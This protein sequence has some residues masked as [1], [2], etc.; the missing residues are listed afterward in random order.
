MRSVHL[1][2]ALLVL[3]FAAAAFWLVQGRP[4]LHWVVSRLKPM[5]PPARFDPAFIRLTP[6]DITQLPVAVRFDY[7]MGSPHGALTYNAQPFRIKMHLGD[8]L[9]GIGG[10]NSDLGDPAYAAGAGRVIFAGK[11]GTGWG[12]MIILAHRVPDMTDPAEEHVVQTVYAHLEDMHVELGQVV[13]RG[14]LIGTVGNASGAYLAHLHFEIRQ[15]PYV[16][17]SVGYATGPLNRL[18]PE[19]FLAQRRGAADNVLNPPPR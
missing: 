1:L 10:Q 3:T 5:P 13:Q 16:N 14:E 4:G 11:P 12:N 15:G 8:D 17:P 7:P 9:N 6:E 18:S 19:R 2:S